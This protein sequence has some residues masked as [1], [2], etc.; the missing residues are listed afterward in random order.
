MHFYFLL[1]FLH[2]RNQSHRAILLAQ[3]LQ[4]I[5]DH[6][7]GFLVERAKAFVQKE[8]VL[9]R[10]GN[11]LNIVGQGQSQA[12]RS[13]KSLSPRQG[14]NTTHLTAVQK[15]SYLKVVVWGEFET[16]LLAGQMKEIG[17]ASCRERV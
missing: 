16:Q 7:Q 10:S 3:G 4:C 17:R 2:M 14:F 9:I 5:K 6:R 8:E 15:V 11:L 1:H 12:Q 13:L